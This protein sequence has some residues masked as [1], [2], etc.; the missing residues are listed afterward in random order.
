MLFLGFWLG[1]G[2]GFEVWVSKLL[3]AAFAGVSRCWRLIVVFGVLGVKVL[4][5][6]CSC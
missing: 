4:F 2:L 1:L 3:V 5:Q 6:G